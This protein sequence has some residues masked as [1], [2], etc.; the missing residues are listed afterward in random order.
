MQPM[1]RI[2]YNTGSF[3]MV[4]LLEFSL[5]QKPIFEVV[6]VSLLLLISVWVHGR[7]IETFYGP[8]EVEE[9][10]LLELINHKNTG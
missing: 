4:R 6:W 5:C 8:I 7:E 2:Y 10:V 1:F 3:S 9:P